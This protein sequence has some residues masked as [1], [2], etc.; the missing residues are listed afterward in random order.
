MKF[1]LK[2]LAISI[3]SIFGVSAMAANNGVNA[4]VYGNY[5]SGYATNGGGVW[6]G[7]RG[8][9]NAATVPNYMGVPNNGCG[10]PLRGDGSRIVYD[11]N[12]GNQIAV[13]GG[14]HY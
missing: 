1:Y 12:T 5:S 8:E 14:T 4:D 7:G 6:Q 9:L 13:P 10:G 2:L 11:P 3:P